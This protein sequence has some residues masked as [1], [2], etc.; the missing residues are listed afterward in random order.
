VK[1]NFKDKINTN[2]FDKNKGNINRTGANRKSIATVNV[3][4]EAKGYKAASKQ[5]ILDCYLRLIN[6][7]LNELSAMV[8][9][10]DQPAMIR[11]VGKA[12]LS[13]KGFDVIEK[14]LDRGI[15]KAELKTDNKHTFEN[16]FDVIKKLYADET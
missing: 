1:E 6:I 13:G 5:D 10:D 4:L 9:S 15:G 11:I 3:E 7:D 14:V 12:I 8:N 2:G 16:G